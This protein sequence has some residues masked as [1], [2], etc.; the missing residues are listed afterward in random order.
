MDF[1]KYTDLAEKKSIH[2]NDIDKA[3]DIVKQFII[4][5]KR[6]LY[7]GLCLDINLRM[8]GHVGIYNDEAIPDY[9]ILSPTFYDDSN[10][11]AVLLFNSGLPN[12]S[13][14]NAAH[15]NSRRVRVN[16]ITVCDISYIPKKIFD[17]I[18]Y[19]TSSIK[20]YKDML[21]VHPDF[22]RLD[23]HRSFNIPFSNPPLEVIL[24][25]LNKDQKR[26]R[27]LDGLYPINIVKLNNKT[28]DVKINIT[29]LEN[30]VVSGLLGYI[31]SLNLLSFFIKKPINDVIMIKFDFDKNIISLPNELIDIFTI[32]LLSCDF[33]S[34]LNSLKHYDKSEI[35]YYHKYLDN[36]RPRTIVINTNDV[37]YEIFDTNGELV[38]CY[39][40]AKSCEVIGFNKK[41]NFNLAQPNQLLLYFMQKSFENDK[42]KILYRSLY[43]SVLN[44]VDVAESFYLEYELT[45]DIKSNVYQHIPWFLS[46]NTYGKNNWS[47]D[48]VSN[49]KEKKYKNQVDKPVTRPV[50]GYYPERSNEWPV[51]EIEKSQLFNID[52]SECDKFEKLSLD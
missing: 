51:F 24:H 1:K 25:R 21:V 26:F 12:I 6:I 28:T 41:Y 49:I 20:K 42:Y 18:P 40:F 31:F 16:F 50:F 48:Y 32:N 33:E 11:L 19:I 44:M 23:L 38:P 13:S 5:K 14:I 9:D 36:I 10:E 37:A 22:Q 52:G 15:F 29:L 34:T 4:N 3:F 2:F 7:G 8:A 30:C 27:I 45:N 47:I 17:K 35:K 39:N 46:C 43:Q